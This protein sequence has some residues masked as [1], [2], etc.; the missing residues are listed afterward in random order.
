MSTQKGELA[1]GS[2]LLNGSAVA[3]PRSTAHWWLSGAQGTRTVPCLEDAGVP[4]GSCH[5]SHAPGLCQPCLHK[6]TQG[7]LHLLFLPC[8]CPQDQTC[9]LSLRSKHSPAHSSHASCP[10]GVY[11][12]KDQDPDRPFICTTGHQCSYLR[13]SSCSELVG[14]ISCILI[15]SVC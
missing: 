1:E 9:C 4:V 10:L 8:S 5:P 13:S 3:P 14:F 12:A 11:F 6:G 2:S 7:L 15:L